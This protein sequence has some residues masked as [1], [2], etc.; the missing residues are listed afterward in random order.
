MHSYY[1]QIK[2]GHIANNCL[3]SGSGYP[4]LAKS[5]SRSKVHIALPEA[6]MNSIKFQMDTVVLVLTAKYG[7]YTKVLG[8]LQR[9]N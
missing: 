3:L 7:I 5:T 8:N 2:N 9:G 1:L 6:Q 4:K